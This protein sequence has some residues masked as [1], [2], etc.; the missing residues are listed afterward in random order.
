MNP[1]VL[2]FG[3][4]LVVHARIFPQYDG[5]FEFGGKLFKCVA[6]D[7]P[8]GDAVVDRRMP[9]GFLDACL[10]VGGVPAGPNEL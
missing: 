1:N 7:Y 4:F 2:V 8:G 6:D 3:Y 5:F 10:G 9:V